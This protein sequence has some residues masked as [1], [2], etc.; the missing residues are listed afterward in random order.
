ME[1]IHERISTDVLIIGSGAAACMAALEATKYH[2]DI[3]LV[4]QGRLGRSGSS[5]TAGAGTAAAFGHTVLGEK[6]NPDTPRQ[7]FEDIVRKGR[8][9][10]D[11]KL[12]RILVEE[13]RD[14]IPRLIEIGIPYEMTVDGLFYQN[15]GVGQ[16]YARNCTP[17]GNGAIVTEILL[18]ETGFRGVSFLERT[19]IIKLFKNNN[20]V[21]GALGINALKKKLYFISAKSI[22][23]AAGS[24]TALQNYASASFKTTGDSFWLAYDAGADLSN[25]EILEFS[26]VPLLDQKAVPC[27]GST[28]LT[29]RGSRFYNSLG[30]RF[31]EKYNPGTLE[32]TTR[33][34]LISAFYREMKAGRG[35]VYMDCASIAP[36]LWRNWEKIG[37]PF[38]NFMKAAG[39]DYETGRV[40]LV[41]ALHCFLGGIVIDQW[42]G[43]GVEGLY[44]AGEA[45]TGIHGA[46]RLGGNAF[47][48]CFV[49]GKRAGAQAATEAI[50]LGN[51]A[52]DENEVGS[53]F[54]ALANTDSKNG[55]TD[56]TANLDKVK[57]MAWRTI[58][59]VRNRPELLKGFEFF[60]EMVRQVP[61]YKVFNADELNLKVTL[62]N[63]SLTAALSSRA[64]LAREETRGGHDREDFP[65]EKSDFLVNFVFNR[66]NR[67]E[68]RQEPIRFESG[69]LIPETR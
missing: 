55:A 51:A 1:F 62:R 66:K 8:Y 7:H 27:G 9:L 60:E 50:K 21:V 68:S 11:Q 29:S 57:D 54:N 53:Y 31:M 3:L 23:I 61:E 5:A 33:A 65:E 63:L 18:K 25:M 38:L 13:I 37:H 35:P 19:R 59:V 6:G 15:Q 58:G 22:I 28:Q 16:T 48:E 40:H 49:F 10:S 12:V 52:I 30:Q 69:D 24:A 47:A 45:T 14:I 56:L 36:E 2:V 32:K 44:A 20:R 41:P 43:T 34:V 4:D 26:F 42:G 17:K 39:I 64:S 46:V 67:F